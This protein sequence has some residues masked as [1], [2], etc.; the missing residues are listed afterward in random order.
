[1]HEYFPADSLEPHDWVERYYAMYDDL[2]TIGPRACRIHVG[3]TASLAREL[4]VD[5]GGMDTVLKLG[6]DISLG[7]RLGEAGAV[8]LPDREARSWHLGRTHVM[9]RRA[10]VNDYNDCFL[11]DRLPELRNKRRAG[12]LYAVPY[13]EVVLD[14]TGLPHASVVA[15]VDA[16][17]GGTLPDL[18]VTLV[19]PWSDLDDAR[20][21]PLDDPMLDTRLV[22][23][24]YAG[25]PRVQLVESLP[26]GRC[27]AMFRMTLENAAWAPTHK[28]VARLLHNMER[29]HHGLRLIRMPDGSTARIERTAAMSRAQRVIKSGEF[30]DDVLDELFGAWTF[31]AA[32]V[33]FWPCQEVHR[34]RMQGTAGE[35][36]D[37]ATAWDHTDVP[38]APSLKAEARAEARTEARAARATAKPAPSGPVPPPSL[39]RRAART[40][41]EPVRRRVAAMLGRR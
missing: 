37:P 28:S 24:S 29:T 30:L 3:A 38:V 16:V 10:E 11:S 36:E 34:P 31:E 8:F 19:G 12:R 5:S 22:W 39:V 20:T 14:T 27:P 33:G 2:R 26:E 23:A 41:P 40:L 35:A 4:Y 32:E 1:M 6:E 18:T 15:T 7:Y 17:L 13:L 21:S 9:Q 25:D